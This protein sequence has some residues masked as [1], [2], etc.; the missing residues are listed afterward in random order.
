MRSCFGEEKAVHD[1]TVVPGLE[2]GFGSLARNILV[3]SNKKPNL[4]KFIQLA[5]YF[6]YYKKYEVK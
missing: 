6:T 4:Q 1:G 5:D 3:A 2:Y